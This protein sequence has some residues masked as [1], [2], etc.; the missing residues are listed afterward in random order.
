MKTRFYN[1]LLIVALI[2]CTKFDFTASEDSQQFIDSETDLERAVTGAYSKFA[3]LLADRYFRNS[4]LFQ[5]M[6]ADDYDLFTGWHC[7]GDSCT[8][9]GCC[10][11]RIVDSNGDTA[12]LGSGCYRNYNKGEEY[13]AGKSYLEFMEG[14][15]RDLYKAI[16][17]QNYILTKFE[18]EDTE[19]PSVNAMLGEVYYMRAYT[20]FRLTRFFGQVPLITDIDVNYQ[21]KRASFKEIY[22]QIESDLLSAVYLLPVSV[23]TARIP[24]VT[25]SRGSAKALLA[26]VYLTM[27]GY[28]LHDLAKY[29]LSAQY[30][31]EVIDSAGIF[32]FGLV[33]DF[34]E[35]YKLYP[36]FNKEMVNIV[37]YK[38]FFDPDILNS[39]YMPD[40]ESN[41][42]SILTRE[43][44]AEVKFF[45][46]Y[47][48]SYRKDCIYNRAHTVNEHLDT[49]TWEWVSDTVYLERT[50]SCYQVPLKKSNLFNVPEYI[51]AKEEFLLY[52]LRY[53][54]TLLT[55]AEASAR[56]GEI[57]PMSY[58]ALN[59]VRR[60]AQR[61]SVTSSSIYDITE[62]L[63]TEQ[64]LDSVVW[65][66]AWEC[67]GDPEGRW[68]D[69]LRL[70]M[71]GSLN[72]LRDAHEAPPPYDGISKG[73]YFFPIPEYDIRLNPN[74]DEGN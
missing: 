74:L 50:T 56:A 17:S 7:S 36:E 19:V 26:E 9:R 70:E 29:R 71:I 28:P 65:E 72:T 58:E 3:S 40:F 44:F 66:R 64:F 41:D 12:Y 48:P 45:N 53:A 32:G 22:N 55:Y 31:K 68:F 34:A 67:T 57:N 14:A 39:H 18:G 51:Q 54:H 11:I 27:G 24:Y 1:I 43:A 16:T 73:E 25:P 49:I 59:M 10:G 38:S 37:Q 61:E 47:P 63:T 35:L 23:S 30:A 20:Y 6:L 33:D 8:P 52:I 5:G 60:R 42:L 15:Y 46:N 13:A 62:G 69:L 21:V 4:Y 2:A